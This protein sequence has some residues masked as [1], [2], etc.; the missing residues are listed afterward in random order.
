[1]N[2]IFFSTTLLIFSLAVVT[3]VNS[4]QANSV[5]QLPHL[6]KVDD[7]N[8]SKTKKNIVRLYPNPT[9]DGNLSISSNTLSGRVHFYVFD[10][11]GTMIHQV[12]LK[13]KQKHKINNLRKGIYLYDVFVNDTSIEQG[14]I[15]VK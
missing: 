2:R 6:V 11:E 1:M 4:K 13:D 9:W 14:R 10:L 5:K 15:V 3:A 8:P 12:E 7:I